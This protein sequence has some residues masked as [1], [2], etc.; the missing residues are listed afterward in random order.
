MRGWV[1]VLKEEPIQGWIL[2][3]SGLRGYVGVIKAED[4]CLGQVE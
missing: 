1:E 3:S 4:L 2:L